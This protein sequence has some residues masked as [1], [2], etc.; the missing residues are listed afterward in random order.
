MANIEKMFFQVRVKKE[1]Q[2]FL[3]FLWWPNG[4]LEQ[5]AEE[6]CMTVHLF[7]AV[8][9][10]ACANYALQCTADDNEESYGT[11]VA[12]TLRRNFYVADVLKS[13]ST[14]DKTIKLA[15]DVKA[16]CEND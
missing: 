7:G 5:K 1:D 9:S 4:G 16:V 14:E 2:S 6:Y 8:S 11:E 15:K 13:G 10:P 3:R 12:K